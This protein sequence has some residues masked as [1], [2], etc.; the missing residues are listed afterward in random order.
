MNAGRRRR[1]L[2]LRACLRWSVIAS[3][4]FPPGGREGRPYELMSDPPRRREG[5]PAWLRR[6]RR[7]WG[8]LLAWP[9][10]CPTRPT[11]VPGG[12]EQRFLAPCS[13]RS[14]AFLPSGRPRRRLSAVALEVHRRFHEAA[15]VA[16]GRQPARRESG[17]RPARL[18]A[19]HRRAS[20]LE[21]YPS[22]SRLLGGDGPECFCVAR[23]LP[24][25]R[26]RRARAAGRAAR[27]PGAGACVRAP[28]G[29]IEPR[30]RGT[31]RA[32]IQLPAPTRDVKTLLTLLRLDPRRGLPRRRRRRLHSSPRIRLRAARS[33]PSSAPRRSRPTARD[34]DRAIGG[35]L[36]GSDR[37]GSP[38]AR[39]T[40][41]APSA[42]PRRDTS[43][44]CRRRSACSKRAGRGL[45]LGPRPA[46]ASAARGA[47]ASG[48]R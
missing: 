18:R 24:L 10:G 36:L 11:I 8:S 45:L 27:V 46:A 40:V 3:P 48:S 5:G 26:P 22:A 17:P 29:D 43:R 25:R 38:R 37:I 31:T 9:R 32:R 21:P 13:R 39:S 14:R 4:A 23:A 35:A 44:R 1:C 42:S 7:I 12:E 2:Q 47:D 34:H 19:R 41:T 16:R 15:G 30:S 33:S 28:R 6:R 20:A